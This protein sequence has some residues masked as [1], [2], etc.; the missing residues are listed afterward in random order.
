MIVFRKRN[1]ERRSEPQP[2]SHLFHVGQAVRMNS[3]FGTSPA[4]PDLY[5]VTATLPPR[6]NSPQYRIRSNE[7]RHER[8]VTED[9]LE[10]ADSQTSGDGTNLI[11]RTYGHGEGTETQQPRDT[12]AK[13]GKGST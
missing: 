3:R 1:E 2:A 9:T 11:E 7:E 5:H 6:N 12:K 10:A 13:A 8:V 4:T